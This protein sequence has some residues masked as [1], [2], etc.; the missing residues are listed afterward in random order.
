MK[1]RLLAFNLEAM[2]LLVPASV[3][4][5]YFWLTDLKYFFMADLVITEFGSAFVQ[6]SSLWVMVSRV[7]PEYAPKVAE[8]R[9]MICF[10]L[11]VKASALLFKIMKRSSSMGL[12]LKLLKR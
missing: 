7:F 5:S 2:Y 4:R 1:E 9:S 10:P 3:L 11:S 6:G 8:T 12:Y